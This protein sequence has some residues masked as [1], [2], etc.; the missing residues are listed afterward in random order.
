LGYF[1]LLDEWGFL[2]AA[3]TES[4]KDLDRWFPGIDN[5]QSVADDGGYFAPQKCSAERR[6]CRVYE[7]AVSRGASLKRPDAYAA[8]LHASVECSPADLIVNLL[9]C[10]WGRYFCRLFPKRKKLGGVDESYFG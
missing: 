2:A 9:V 10:K 3:A 4:P 6:I 8:R 1:A 5:F 7:Y